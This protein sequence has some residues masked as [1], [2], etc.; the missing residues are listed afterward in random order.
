MG[1]CQ[2]QRKP[3]LIRRGFKIAVGA[4]AGVVGESTDV[5]EVGLGG[6]AKRAGVRF[7]KSDLTPEKPIPTVEEKQRR[8]E[9]LAS[10]RDSDPLAYAEK[11]IKL[12]K[13]LH[14][15]VAA[16]DQSVK[17][18]LDKQADKGEQSQATK[19]VAIGVGK[20]V[21]LWQSPNNEGYASVVVDGHWENYRI[22]S[23]GFRHWLLHEYGKRNQVEVDGQLVPQSPGSGAVKDAMAQLEG[24][25]LFRGQVAPPAIRVGGMRDQ[26]WID[27][28]D[29][30]WGTVRVT[31]EG[32]RPE[33]Q[34]PQVAFVRGT[35]MQALP[36]PIRGGSIQ[37]LRRVLNV[38]PADFVLC[39]GWMLQALNSVGPYPVGWVCGP[40]EAGKSTVTRMLGRTV[41][42]N[43]LQIRR[44]TRKSDD[45]LIAARN[46]WT[47]CIDNMSY[48]TGDLSDLFCTLSTG[49]ATG[50]R[51]H[52]TDDEEHGFEVERPVIINGIPTELI[53]R[54]DLASRSICFQVLPISVRKTDDELESE[55]LEM[56]SGVFGAL[57]DGLVAG[58][59]DQRSIK[60]D[61]PARLMDFER[62]AEAGCRAMGF[63]EWEFVEAYAANRRGTMV[64]AL[65][66]SSVGRVVLQFM[67]GK[68]GKTKG[69]TGKMESLKEILDRVRGD[70]MVPRDW[71]KDPA[72][73]ST[74]LDRLTKPL[75]A[76]G[77]D[78]MLRVDLRP[79]T[80]KGVIL[81]WR[82]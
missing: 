53:E 18:I 17:I 71:P 6:V 79:L 68:T 34:M 36:K 69:F 29:E 14:T 57:L 62:F 55:F 65:E 8:L 11:R 56:W 40:S 15:T 35:A 81:R 20:R 19:I 37:G 24:I 48:M 1:Q 38:Q 5:A 26:I 39:V 78:C 73:L 33:E 52:Y 61:Y 7:H 32:W 63:G 58:L 60:V 25:A 30:D 46:N 4:S 49:I 13:E 80:Q 47:I 31:A 2:A 64:T 42:P 72:R 74:A 67:N 10:L 23:R 75:A 12:A 43:S 76:V 51:K 45:L 50:T 41:D 3:K 22:E 21:R 27:L 54:G 70:E 82:S 66:S 16:I 59:R 9:E 44:A 28:G 77:I